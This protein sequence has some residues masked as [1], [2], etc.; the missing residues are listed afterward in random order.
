MCHLICLWV[1]H[2]GLDARCLELIM[3]SRTVHKWQS[4]SI[5]FEMLSAL[6]L[7]INGLVDHH[8]LVKELHCP[9]VPSTQF[10]P[11]DWIVRPCELDNIRASLMSQRIRLNTNRHPMRNQPLVQIHHPIRFP[12]FNKRL[13]RKVLLD[14]QVCNK[15][16]DHKALLD[17]QVCIRSLETL[18]INVIYKTSYDEHKRNSLA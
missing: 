11:M 12:L 13:E 10:H 6:P 5:R 3:H 1:M 2:T 15:R 8:H 14:H 17:H 9:Q 7:M 4:S 18:L 16:L